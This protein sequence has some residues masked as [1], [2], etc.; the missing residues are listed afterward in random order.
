MRYDKPAL[1]VAD[2][3][4]RLQQRGLQCADEARVQHYLTHIGYYRLSAYWLPFEQPATDGQP[5]DHQFQPG[6]NFEQVL[7]LYIFDRQLRLLVMEAIERIETAIRTHWAHAL[8]MRHGPHA[9]LDASLFKSPWQHARAC[10]QPNPECG[11]RPWY[12][13]CQPNHS[14]GKVN[15]PQE[16]ARRLVV[17]RGNGTVLLEPG[18]KVLNQVAL[19]VQVPVVA[20]RLLAV[21]AR[22]DHDSFA[23]ALQRLDQAL[24]CVVGFISDN[25]ISLGV[26][27]Q[28]VRPFKIMALP[29]REVKTGRIAQGIDC[30]VNLRAQTASAAP[31]SLFLRIPPFAPALCWWARTMVESIMAYSL[32][33]SCANAS[34]TRCQTPVLLQREWRVCTTRKSP[35]CSGKS[36]QGMPAR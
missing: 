14:S 6:T 11:A 3:V 24:L 22:G 28:D 20:A 17:A 5:R 15:Y 27:K 32:S 16:I 35:K 2:Q 25:A 36:R 7:S 31:D 21:A 33:A 19:L 10:H 26:L 9:H 12:L 18:K 13:S 23:F 4:A 29:G 34:K 1:S 30:G 8:A